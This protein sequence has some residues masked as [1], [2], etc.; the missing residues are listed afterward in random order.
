MKPQKR[1]HKLFGFSVGFVALALL[2][3]V[4]FLSQYYKN[5]VMPGVVI[6]GIVGNA[7][8]ETELKELINDKEKLFNLTVQFGLKN[9]HQKLKIWALRSI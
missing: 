4:G 7:K 6:A 2:V 1:W 9:T 3:I 8:T 5:R